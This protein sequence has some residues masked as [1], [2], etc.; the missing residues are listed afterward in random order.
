MRKRLIIASVVFLAL[1]SLLLFTEP[2]E[3]ITGN[4]VS[5]R[6][7]SF[8][9][10]NSLSSLGPLTILGLIGSVAVIAVFEIRKR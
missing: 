2:P 5:D 8:F 3:N 6:I 7:T 1:F 9:V 10:G 4:A